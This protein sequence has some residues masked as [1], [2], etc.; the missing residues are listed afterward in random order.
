VNEGGDSEASMVL[1]KL[2]KVFFTL[3]L[4]GVLASCDPPAVDVEEPALQVGTIANVKIFGHHYKAEVTS[5]NEGYV[6]WSYSW[7][8]TPVYKFKTYRGLMTVFSVEE[9]F[10]RSSTFDRET[11]DALFPLEVGKEASLEGIN[12]SEREG[13]ESPFW[14]NIFVREKTTIKIKKSEYPVYI[15]DFSFIED[16]PDGTKNYIKT[17]WY[18]AEMETSLRTDFAMGDETFS[19]RVISLNSPDDFK[20]TDENEPEGL[21]TVRL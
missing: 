7:K 15:I 14:V 4:L 11:L 1:N 12:W 21:G 19:M 18:S 6:V 2:I 5:A 16:H 17:I 20:D 3:L 13:V 9:G 8:Q 10:K